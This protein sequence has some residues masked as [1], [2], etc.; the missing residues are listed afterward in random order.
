MDPQRRSQNRYDAMDLREQKGGRTGEKNTRVEK[1]GEEQ[2]V[3]ARAKMEKMGEKG[4]ANK[5]ASSYFQCPVIAVGLKRQMYNE[6]TNVHRI[7]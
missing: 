4:A 6:P 5:S 2:K 7:N 3:R 1:R